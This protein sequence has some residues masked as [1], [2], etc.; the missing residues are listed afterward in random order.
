MSPGVWPGA[1][2]HVRAMV[3]TVAAVAL[4]ATPSCVLLLLNPMFGIDPGDRLRALAWTG[5]LGTVGPSAPFIAWLTVGAVHRV[6]RRVLETGGRLCP[7]C[8][9]DL[10]GRPVDRGE[11]APPCP[12]CGRPITTRDAVLFWVRQLRRATKP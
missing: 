8:G 3:W 7:F 6:E 5:L 10:T 4:I 2:S 12:E 1:E 11:G 9:H